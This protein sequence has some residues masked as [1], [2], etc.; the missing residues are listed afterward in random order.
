MP[1]TLD[2]DDS[3]TG[4]S[5]TGRPNNR[6]LT[7]TTTDADS[8]AGLSGVAIEFFADGRSLGSATTDDSGTATLA[9]PP[10]YRNGSHI[11]EA[12]FGGNDY[13]TGS[14]DTRQT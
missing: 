4:V 6:G 11:Y 1:F 2:R 7:A 13:Y 8:S 12:V 10:R 3:A 14:S 9:L 5:L